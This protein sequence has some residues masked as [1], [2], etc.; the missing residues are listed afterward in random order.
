MRVT[1]GKE[2]LVQSR[3]AHAQSCR[4][5]VGPRLIDA[6]ESIGQITHSCVHATEM[7]PRC[8]EKDGESIIYSHSRH[9]VRTALSECRM[10]LDYNFFTS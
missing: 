10:A 9:F 3:S 8:P 6:G 1:A 2:T 4:V 7:T 5:K